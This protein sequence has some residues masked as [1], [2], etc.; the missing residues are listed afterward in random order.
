MAEAAYNA[1]YE[2]K[3]QIFFDALSHDYQ[4][5]W[6]TVGR[7]VVLVH[8]SFR[9]KKRQKEPREY[10]GSEEQRAQWRAQAQRRRERIATK[11]SD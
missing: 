5:R 10:K 6:V 4:M 8:D 3:P 9:H 11:K 7:E 1:F 2:Q